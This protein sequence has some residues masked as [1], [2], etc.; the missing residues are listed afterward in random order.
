MIL[1]IQNTKTGIDLISLE[2][3]K[4]KPVGACFWVKCLETDVAKKNYK[5]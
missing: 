1:S 5:Q 3:D 4:I 2:V